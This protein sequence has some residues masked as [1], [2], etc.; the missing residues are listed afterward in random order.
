MSG[1]NQSQLPPEGQNDET[2]P[3]NNFGLG[4]ID[5]AL[6]DPALIDP[7]LMDPN[8]GFGINPQQLPPSQPPA[9]P[10]RIPAAA[11]ALTSAPT[12]TPTA[13]RLPGSYYPYQSLYP[14][15][16]LSNS[17]AS[18]PSTPAF[19]P[20]TTATPTDTG[21]ANTGST[22]GTKRGRASPTDGSALPKRIRRNPPRLSAVGGGANIDDDD[23]DGPEA[24]AR[25]VARPVAR[26][27]RAAARRIQVRKHR[28]LHVGEADEVA[29]SMLRLKPKPKKGAKAAQ[30]AQDAEE[31]ENDKDSSVYGRGNTEIVTAGTICDFC[32]N[33]PTGKQMYALNPVCDWKQIPNMGAGVYNLECGNCANYRS[34]NR[35]PNEI[36]NKDDHLCR[37]PGPVTALIDF[38]HKKYGDADPRTY[39]HRACKMCNSK[40]FY[41][42]CDVDTTLGYFC[43]RCRRD[44]S[45]TI[46]K[47]PQPMK[48]PIKLT[49]PPW[50]RHACDRCLMRHKRFEAMPQDDCCSWLTDRSQWEQGSGCT[51]CF[52][53]GAI[54]M[55]SDIV[56]AEPTYQPVPSTW[57]I[58][59]R[60]EVEETEKKKERKAKWHEY[61]E[62]TMQTKWRRKCQC[63]ES[64][65]R[66]TPCLVMWTQ[67]YHACERCTQFGIECAAFDRNSKTFT[68]Y[69]IYDLSRVGFGHF[70][71]YTVCDPC[72]KKGRKCDRQRPCD[73][74]TRS[75]VD[76]CDSMHKDIA[77][78]CVARNRS[79][80]NDNPNNPQN[81]GPLY[82]L[83]L[84]YGPGGVD[85]IKDGRNPEHWIG[86]IA[87]V[88]GIIEQNQSNQHYRAIVELHREHRPP[89]GVMPPN[90]TNLGALANTKPRELTTDQLGD[91]ITRLWDNPK[92]PVSDMAAYRKIWDQLRDA[93]MDKMKEAGVDTLPDMNPGVRG[94][95]GNPVLIDV[96]YMHLGLSA[97]APNAIG[98]LQDAGLQL[99]DQEP[100][101]YQFQYQPFGD[102][103]L[104]NADGLITHMPGEQSC[105]NAPQQ[106][107][108]VNQQAN[109]LMGA[110]DFIQAGEQ[111]A[112]TP[113]I[114]ITQ[115]GQDEVRALFGI[116]EVSHERS[117]ATQ[118]QRW[119][120]PRASGIGK[121]DREGTA[122]WNRVPMDPNVKKAFNP[123]LGFVL[124]QNQKPR[125]KA[126]SKS[127]RWKTFNPLEDLNMD[128][129]R[130]STNKP[131]QDRSQ[132]HLFSVING[133]TNQPVPWRDV[134]GDVP[135][136]RRGERTEHCCA[137][138]GEG[139]IGYCG[140][141]NTN[142]QDQ[143]TCQSLTHRNTVPGYL[144]ICNDCTQGNVRD[145]FHHEYNPITESELL[146]M[147]AYLCNDCAGHISNSAQ[148][149]AQYRVIGAR[150]I[151][152]V[153][154]D[155]E[156]P[157]TTYQPENDPSSVVE[158][159][160]DTEALTGCSCAN[161]MLGTSLCRFHR[162]YYAEEAL[163]N[164][165]MIQE[166]RLSHFKKAVCPSCLAQKPL[167]QVNLSADFGG[168]LSDAPTAW[169]CVNCN[170]WVANEK[171]GEGNQPGVIDKALWNLNVGRELLGPRQGMVPG[172][173]YAADDVEMMDG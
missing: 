92:V 139:G 147:R 69:P 13:R 78:G 131:A 19:T 143:A 138:P 106:Q 161:R 148:N 141:W 152:G 31:D 23:D 170:D 173:I 142:E 117:L 121:P 73:S 7:A 150:R 130:R 38:K 25:P 137:E 56:V 111:E 77:H 60:F 86:P 53:D 115:L 144:P 59:P 76:K 167:E 32:A 116:D 66:T 50:Y 100:I 168:F 162:L 99:L 20:S 64:A 159:Q 149:A 124:D 81:P 30:A 42:T 48:R 119:F 11:P 108:N 136:K 172:R 4:L 6:I 61:V 68:R 36:A 135:Y 44:Q 153:V 125:F 75:R 29:E 17:D 37:V 107:E 65:G 95:Q 155:K 158:F 103:D 12:L 102:E 79:A 16:G 127:S 51:R 74:C 46:D 126:N 105:N 90:G 9:V 114:D 1:N 45:C 129:W 118:K 91:M 39:A 110:A 104:Y 123:F 21:S 146:S 160:N 122:F 93:Q 24:S 96:E 132:P 85:S 54:C 133:Q 14:D 2:N 140:S 134:L 18:T 80:A 5:P 98:Q 101:D 70:T 164:S 128:E 63:C 171:N 58:R 163:K 22:R 49:R 165:A 8:L 34:R 82:Y 154:A 41:D 83:A 71:P 120:L 84:G 47:I 112:P 89:Q 169:A 15:F 3:Q 27:T 94:F 26:G 145:L 156:R 62:V 52:L 88:Y 10:S 166:W 57:R 55:D 109:N 40:K 72:V 43:T 113:D 151:Y 97:G 28:P 33:H 67:P 35:Q 87:P 157:Q